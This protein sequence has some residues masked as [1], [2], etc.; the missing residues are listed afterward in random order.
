MTDLRQL[1]KKERRLLNMLDGVERFIKDYEPTRDECQVSVRLQRL[2]ALGKEFYEVRDQIELLMDAESDTSVIDPKREEEDRLASS[3]FE[4]RYCLAKALLE[5]KV[6]PPTTSTSIG[7]GQLGDQSV[8]FSKVKLPEIRLPSF[9][10]NLK[11][12]VTFRDSFRS[13][14][15]DNKQLTDMDRFSYL[16]SSLTGE[17]L[18]E[19][20]SVELS[21]ANYSV[22]WMALVSRY[23]NKKLIVKAHLDTLFC[24]GRLDT[25]K[26]RGIEQ[27]P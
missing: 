6:L 17:A 1:T 2:E 10:G 8:S 23:E 3:S 24:S 7:N 16:K 27:P 14:I 5:K 18:Q 11:D 4:D 15:H 13:L 26:L 25:I 19:V 21:S 20:D 9:S 12:W 22:A